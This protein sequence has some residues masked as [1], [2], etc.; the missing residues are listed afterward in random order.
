MRPVTLPLVMSLEAGDSAMS[1]R[2]KLEVRANY[3][4]K[5]LL[6]VIISSSTVAMITSYKRFATR[7]LISLVSLLCIYTA[8]LSSSV[9]LVSNCITVLWASVTALT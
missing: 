1:C 7:P 5:N 3:H 9:M 6:M 2:V 4:H 8:G